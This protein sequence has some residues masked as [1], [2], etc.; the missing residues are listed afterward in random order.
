MWP[1]KGQ[2]RLFKITEGMILS[3]NCEAIAFKVARSSIN[4][5][6]YEIDIFA[7]RELIQGAVI[8]QY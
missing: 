8:V 4:H 1:F 5:G 2:E 7:L 3:M 6:L